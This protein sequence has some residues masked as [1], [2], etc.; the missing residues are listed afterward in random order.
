MIEKFNA[1]TLR[2]M[3]KISEMVPY[4]KQKKLNLKNVM[5]KMQNNILEKIIIIIM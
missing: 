1:N 4:L 5:K 2:P 3:M